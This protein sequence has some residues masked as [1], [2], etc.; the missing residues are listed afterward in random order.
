M[1]RDRSPPCGA[2]AK[3]CFPFCQCTQSLPPKQPCLPSDLVNARV[4][5]QSSCVLWTV[6]QPCYISHRGEFY[7]S[8]RCALLAEDWASNSKLPAY[9]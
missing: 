9:N 8:D 7:S 5:L 6:E 3:G 1:R 4:H 2:D